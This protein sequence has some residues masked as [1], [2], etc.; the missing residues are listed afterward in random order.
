M[1]AP[2]QR[3]DLLS[4]MAAQNSQL[5][6]ALGEIAEEIADVAQIILCDGPINQAERA[7]LMEK[8]KRMQERAAGQA[9][10]Q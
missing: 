6:Q 7:A 1:S 8:L 10:R 5:R 4:A 2:I 9:V 3:H